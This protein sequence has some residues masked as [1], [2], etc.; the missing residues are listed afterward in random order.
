MWADRHHGQLAAAD[1]DIVHQFIVNIDNDKWALLA[2][3][4]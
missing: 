1:D 3:Q 4:C 2:K